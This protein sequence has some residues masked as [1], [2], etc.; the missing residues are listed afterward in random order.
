VSPNDAYHIRA[1]VEHPAW[2]PAD[3]AAHDWTP[4]DI[5]RA[6]AAATDGEE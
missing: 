1:E 3:F 2:E 6:L 5:A 4:E